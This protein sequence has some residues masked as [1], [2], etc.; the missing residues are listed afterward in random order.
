MKTKNSL[1]A[2]VSTWMALLFSV[3]MGQVRVFENVD[4]TVSQFPVVQGSGDPDYGGN[5]SVTIPLLTVPGRGGLDFD[6]NLL[7]VHGNGVPASES[8]SWVGLG[9]NLNMYEITCSP[10]Y[11]PDIQTAGSVLSD[12]KDLYYLNYPGGTT[13]FREFQSGWTPLNWSAIKIEATAY[14]SNPGADDPDNDYAKFV[15]T[16]LEGTRYIFGHKLE[17]DSEKQLTNH[18]IPTSGVQCAH[19]GLNPAGHPYFYVFKLTAVL[20]ANYVDGGGDIYVPGDGGTDN[21]SWIKLAYDAPITITPGGSGYGNLS[22]QVSFL[23]KITTPTHEALFVLT[24]SNDNALIYRGIQNALVKCLDKIQLKKQDGTVIREA[25]FTTSASFGWV[26]ENSGPGQSYNYIY[27][28]RGASYS[29]LSRRLR[30]ESITIRGQGGVQNEPPYSFTYYGEPADL[31]DY[32]PCWLDPWGLIATVNSQSDAYQT[33]PDPNRDYCWMLKKV[34]YPTGGNVEFEYETD[35]YE[36][37]W[38]DVPENQLPGL[39]RVDYMGGVRLFRQIITDPLTSQQSIYSYNYALTNTDFPGGFGFASARITRNLTSGVLWGNGVGA[40]YNNDINYPDIQIT[41]PDNSKIRKYYT[42]AFTSTGRGISG[43]PSLSPYAKSFTSVTINQ[44]DPYIHNTS[45]IDPNVF[46]SA[47]YPLHNNLYLRFECYKG[48]PNNC[49]DVVLP[50]KYFQQDFYYYLMPGNYSA[51]Y[52]ALIHE[53]MEYDAHDFTAFNTYVQLF[54]NK[55]KRGHITYEE[56][57]DPNS[58]TPVQRKIYTYSMQPIKTELLKYTDGSNNNYPGFVTSGWV[59]LTQIRTE[60]RTEPN[61]TALYPF[62]QEDY[63]YNTVNGLVKKL[64]ETNSDNTQRI[65]KF[66]YPVDYLNTSGSGD[67][68]VQALEAMKTTKYMPG[69]VIEKEVR[70]KPTGQSEKVL[71]A[72]LMK[73]KQFGSSA[74]YFPHEIKKVFSTTAITNFTE[75]TVTSGVFIEDSRY[76]LQAKNEQFD[77]H[78]NLTLI[79]DANNTPASIVWAHS[80]TLPIAQ[81]RNALPSQSAAFVFDDNSTSGW[82]GGA[83]T[84]T[85]AGGAYQQTNNT[86]K[87][88]NVPQSNNVVSIDDAVLEAEVRFDDTSGNRY[89]ALAKYVSG[90]IVRFVLR[91]TSTPGAYIYAKN[92]TADSSAVTSKTLSFNKWYRL[93]GEIQGQVA[94]LFLDGELLVT[95]TNSK[96]DLAS[97]NIGLCTNQS[98]ASFDNVRFYPPNALAASV[99]FDPGFFKLSTKTDESSISTRFSFDALGRLQNVNDAAGNLLRNVTYFYSAPFSTSNPNYIQEN[100]YRSGT[101]FTA[102]RNWFDGLGRSVQSQQNEGTGSVKIGTVYDALNRPIKVTKP[103]SS[104][105]Q[106]FT[107]GDP[108]AAANSYYASNHPVYFG[109]TSTYD[110]NPYA[111][112]E[113]AYLPDPLNRPQKQASPGTAYY[114]GSGKEVK[115]DYF[116][117]TALEVT[118]YIENK[119]MKNRR[120]DENGN[121]VNTFTDR[122]GNIISTIVDSAGLNYKTTFKYDVL[123]NLLES[124]DPR[125]LTTTYAYN[126]LSQ[127]R[128]KITPDAGTVEYLYDKNGN[129]R[130][131][132]DA[133]GA[134]GN[135]YFIYYKYDIFN[136]KIEEGTMTAPTSNF[137]QANADNTSYPTSGNTVKIKY[138]YDF[139]GY[140]TSLPQKNLP[141]RMDG[142]E[143]I[144][145]RYTQKGYTFY[146]YDERGRIDWVQNWIPRSN[147]ADGNS[148]LGTRIDYDYDW[149]GNVTKVYFSRTF[150]PGA[151]SDAFY[152]WYDY[153][154]LGRL[155]K[156]FTNTVDVKPSTSNATYTYWPGGQVKRLVLGNTLQGVDYLYN[157]R[158]WLTQIN[159]HSLVKG[160]DPGNDSTNTTGAYVDRFGEIIGYNVSAHIAADGD[161]S[162]DFDDQ[163]NG[164]I[165]WMTSNIYGMSNPPGASLNGWIY[166]Y[167]KANRLTKANWG[168][169]TSVLGT[170]WSTSNN[171]DVSG[172]SGSITYDASGNLAQMT[173]NNQ[174]GTSTAMTYNYFASTNKLSFVA[175][176]NGSGNYDYDANGNMIKDAAKINPT[177]NTILYDYRNLPVQVTKS[178]APAGTI[179]FGYD[180]NGNRVFKNNLFY[181]PG[182][183]GKVLAVYD[184][185]GTHQYWNVWGLDLIGQRYWK[186]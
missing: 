69:V 5:L 124:K 49:Q 29:E 16:D 87:P 121:L 46:D 131:V 100:A 84:W 32:A 82:S 98:K 65:T 63:E 67:P 34:T 33:A 40:N 186:Q 1:Y 14:A 150:P 103:F 176:L 141:G 111:Y 56:Y 22:M 7:Y 178:V 54:D 62:A 137:T 72:E 83:G 110:I 128:Q 25:D 164:N 43:S 10:T 51:E 123:G 162:G 90:N 155:Y 47:H 80:N 145:D 183:D 35:R 122:F 170:N 152:T 23:E 102:S 39:I 20:G 15:V 95:W 57:Y 30:L 3:A 76:Q 58:A 89:L 112:S 27:T 71:A 172:T 107:T 66:K 108:I 86:A 114:M 91:N 185:N 24:T 125:T 12:D 182:A 146:S 88:W 85:I 48:P 140:G 181:I 97:G 104:A 149:Q 45:I 106:T 169:N 31:A 171:Y 77:A 18:C 180:A 154:E 127:L 163:F 96:V 79:Y 129:L 68:Y 167:D 134:T 101:Q 136:R 42:C 116:T 175:N 19:W 93:R 132:K 8:A 184:I 117:N 4:P 28:P 36:I 26:K 144:T 105:T 174:S 113:T 161:Y 168:Y 135:A 11:D 153:D 2:I 179:Y 52:K 148:S 41:R 78:G 53:A 59:K 165:A 142:V 151:S 126:T 120:R 55:W 73:Y 166:K 147:I 138:H 61:S 17:M 156:V 70:E 115:F 109:G 173:R 44:D 81:V 13:P 94:K 119:L 64:T 60:I 177:T 21:G 160:R 159:H 99:S 118:G 139:A 143:Y 92:G 38:P 50:D 130:F 37:P 9:W 133:K 157:S 158:D 75:S 74:Q 6:I